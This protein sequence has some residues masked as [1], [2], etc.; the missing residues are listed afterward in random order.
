MFSVPRL[1]WEWKSNSLL[2]GIKAYSDSAQQG[3]LY[4]YLTIALLYQPA[5]A[6]PPVVVIE[7]MH[8]AVVSK[9]LLGSLVADFFNFF[10]G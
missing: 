7:F 3:R 9:M 10:L 4:K 1:S 6:S 2:H 8:K 5:S